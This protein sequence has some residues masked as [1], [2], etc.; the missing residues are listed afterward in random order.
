MIG[1]EEFTSFEPS[2]PQYKRRRNGN[3]V[4][5]TLRIMDEKCNG[6]TGGSGMTIVLRIR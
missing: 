6:I 3:F 4:S 1:S 2:T 5:L